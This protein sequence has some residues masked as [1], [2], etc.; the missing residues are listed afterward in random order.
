MYRLS[1]LLLLNPCVLVYKEKKRLKEIEKRKTNEEVKNEKK[2]SS[3]ER[4]KK[5]NERKD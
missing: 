4:R 5:M 3:Y 1:R 2:R